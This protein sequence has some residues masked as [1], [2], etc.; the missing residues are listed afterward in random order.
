MDSQIPTLLISVSIAPAAAP[1]LSDSGHFASSKSAAATPILPYAAAPPASGTVPFY[2]SSISFYFSMNC[3]RSAVILL[4]YVCA[5][6]SGFLSVSIPRLS[7][8][9]V[10]CGSDFFLFWGALL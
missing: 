6:S 1:L 2:S 3:R 8:L 7:L 4:P 9:V 5:E 10:C